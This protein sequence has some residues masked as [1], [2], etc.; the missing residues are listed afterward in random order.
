MSDT[1]RTLVCPECPRREQVSEVD[2]DAS[3]SE[4]LS[5]IRWEHP[6]VDQRPEV[7]WPRIDVE[8]GERR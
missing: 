4:M 1:T 5:H 6:E 3:F 2:D 8:L 7:L